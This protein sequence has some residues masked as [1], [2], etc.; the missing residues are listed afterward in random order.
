MTSGA[1][2]RLQTVEYCRRLP[3][4]VDC[5]GNL[6]LCQFSHGKNLK[7]GSSLTAAHV[8]NYEQ[9]QQWKKKARK[10]AEE[11]KIIWEPSSKH[12]QQQQRAECALPSSHFTIFHSVCRLS[13]LLLLVG[14]FNQRQAFN[15]IEVTRQCNLSQFCVQLATCR[16]VWQHATCCPLLLLYL[17]LLCVPYLSARFVAFA[18]AFAVSYCCSCRWCLSLVALP[19]CLTAWL[20][21]SLGHCQV[22]LW[23]AQAFTA[24]S[25]TLTRT[26]S[27]LLSF[28]L[29]PFLLNNLI[30]YLADA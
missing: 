20:P 8:S 19:A 13:L 26:L 28:S 15:A 18:F 10:K 5:L 23:L 1:D 25:C 29:F 3:S 9:Q 22:Q 27:D 24:A 14:K 2:C 12:Q 11:L 4:I 16:T 21:A 30:N 7:K 6:F 17:L